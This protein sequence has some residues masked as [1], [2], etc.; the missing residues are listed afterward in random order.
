MQRGNLTENVPETTKNQGQVFP[1]A[2]RTESMSIPPMHDGSQRA[3]RCCRHQRGREG[4]QPRCRTI[5]KKNPKSTPTYIPGFHAVDH[6][7]IHPVAEI[8]GDGCPNPDELVK[9]RDRAGAF[10]QPG[11]LVE[12]V[13]DVYE[14]ETV[15]FAISTTIVSVVLV[16]STRDGGRVERRRLSA[17]EAR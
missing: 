15:L 4:P 5:H 14:A 3:S 10:Q 13:L 7:A 17:R 16:I 1:N 11:H 12:R 8:T 6:L 9:V 2:P